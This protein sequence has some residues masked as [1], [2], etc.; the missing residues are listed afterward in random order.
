MSGHAIVT[1]GGSGIGRAIAKA[2]VEAGCRVTIMG[3]NRDR[4][5]AALAELAGAQAIVCD[6]ADAEGAQKAVAAAVA[7]HGPV[8]ILVNCAGIVRTAPFGRQSDADWRDMWSTNLM[9]CVHMI[10]PLLDPMKAMPSARIINVAS[11][12]ALK[13][14]AYCTAYAASKHAVLG[15]TRALALELAGTGV[16]VNALCPGYADTDIIQDAVAT[17]MAKTG[18]SEEEA[19]RNFTSTNPQGRLIDPAEVAATVLWL[20]SDQARSITGQAIAIAGGEVM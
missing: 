14:Y 16:T 3:R 17:I 1:G 6:V 20:I 19:L 9:G 4:L 5:N 11:T 15:L 13:G 12:A 18:R 8:R 2:L 10:R 7:A